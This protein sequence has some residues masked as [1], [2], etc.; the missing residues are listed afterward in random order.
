MIQMTIPKLPPS[1]NNYWGAKCVG[2]RVRRWLSKEGR[3]FKELVNWVGRAGNVRPITG[4]VELEV[5]FYISR[6]RDLDNFLK[7]LLDSLQGVTYFNDKQVY[8][9]LAEKKRVKKGEE[10]VEVIIREINVK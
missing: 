7:S 4:E 3:E 5:V 2:E 6:D 8:K 1:V 9:I 10:R